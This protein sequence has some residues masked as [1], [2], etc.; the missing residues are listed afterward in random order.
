MEEKGCYV[1]LRKGCLFSAFS[2]LTRPRAKAGFSSSRY[3]KSVVWFGTKYQSV[4]LANLD[5]GEKVFCPDRAT[6]KLVAAAF[7]RGS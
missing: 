4:F 5:E 2:N 7:G 6:K 1:E 3:L